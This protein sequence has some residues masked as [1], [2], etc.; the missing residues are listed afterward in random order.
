MHDGARTIVHC[1]FFFSPIEHQFKYTGNCRALVL[2][3]IKPSPKTH[4]PHSY[5]I[6]FTLDVWASLYRKRIITD[7]KW[8]FLFFFLTDD[9][10]FVNM[11]ELRTQQN[12][13]RKFMET[14]LWNWST[15][16][17]NVQRT[18]QKRK[19]VCASKYTIVVSKIFVFRRTVV[20]MIDKTKRKKSKSSTQYIIDYTFWSVKCSLLM[21]RIESIERA[22]NEN[23]KKPYDGSAQI[24]ISNGYIK[25]K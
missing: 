12:I 17:K 11:S 21:L 4:L 6:I 25:N 13:W 18:K 5:N 15:F 1:I 20:K 14:W 19:S 2:T 22:T 16:S 9:D 7:M 10:R 8:N 24:S 23:K 3:P